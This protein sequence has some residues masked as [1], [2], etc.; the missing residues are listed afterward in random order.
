MEFTSSFNQIQKCF[1]HIKNRF[2]NTTNK[3]DLN[4]KDL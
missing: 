3:F 2:Y 4:K 1:N